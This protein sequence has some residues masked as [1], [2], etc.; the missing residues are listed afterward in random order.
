[1]RCSR[2]RDVSSVALAKSF[3]ALAISVVYVRGLIDSRLNS[4][5][6]KSERI[7]EVLGNL[8]KLFSG[9]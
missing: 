5:R 9:C 6:D 7:E 1:L 4:R 3:G 2:I 8:P